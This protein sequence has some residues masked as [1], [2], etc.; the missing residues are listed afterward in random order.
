MVGA[1]EYGAQWNSY[2]CSR[3]LA[4]IDSTSEVLANKYMVD[5][6]SESSDLLG[7]YLIAQQVPVCGTEGEWSLRIRDERFMNGW[8]CPREAI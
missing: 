4:P 5:F 6:F 7:N 1:S 8:S 2:P 3:H